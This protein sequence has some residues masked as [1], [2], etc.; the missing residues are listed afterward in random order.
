MCH[1]DCFVWTDGTPNDFATM[2]RPTEPDDGLGEGDIDC[3]DVVAGRRPPCSD[4]NAAMR[5]AT[6]S[7]LT[8]NGQT[9]AQVA[10]DCPIAE[11][12]CGTLGGTGYEPMV[13]YNFLTTGNEPCSCSC[14]PMSE[15][16]TALIGTLSGPVRQR[17]CNSPSKSR[18]QQS[19]RLK[20]D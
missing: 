14:P 13:C 1:S 6:I 20:V 11:T 3:D 16:C 2:W 4:D 18:N 10:R 7:L 12:N 9:C 17:S 8:P 19:E 5:A 15:D